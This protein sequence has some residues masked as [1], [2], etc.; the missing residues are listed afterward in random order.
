[1]G[2]FEILTPWKNKTQPFLKQASLKQNAP[3]LVATGQFMPLTRPAQQIFI[4]LL[5][6]GTHGVVHLAVKS[7]AGN[8]QY[9]AV[10]SSSLSKCSSLVKENRV[11][12]KFTGYPNVIQW[13]GNELSTDANGFQVYRLILEYAPHGTLLDLIRTCAGIV[14][15]PIVRSFNR[16]ILE[17]LACIHDKG[18]FVH[19]DLK[20]EN[21]L[22]FPPV[23]G[24]SLCHLKIA[25]FG[26]SKEPG[27]EELEA[28][29]G[30][31]WKFNFRGTPM[32]MSPDSL[33]NGSITPSLDIWSLGCVV[34]KMLSNRAPWNHLDLENLFLQ[35]VRTVEPPAVPENLS[36]MA[37]D[38]LSR[39]F[40]MDPDE[41]WTANMLLL[42]PFVYPNMMNFGDGEMVSG[43][44]SRSGRVY[45]KIT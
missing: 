6:Q 37:K 32:Y 28:A 41:R 1:M 44:S 3:F 39:C 9:V 40:L 34:M 25:D 35:L 33:K 38:F 4:R 15:E 24:N 8:P 23:D 13:Y 20:P 43:D 2:A 21:I 11:L 18:G 7:N 22:V 19:C 12:S 5:G 27:E 10:N 31:S 16:M 17:G 30:V 36:E 29:V 14:P 45:I 42:H 26:L